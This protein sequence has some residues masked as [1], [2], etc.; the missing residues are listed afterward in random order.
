MNS[1]TFAYVRVSTAEQNTDRQTAEL[2]KYV[3]D[4]K[5][6]IIDKASGKDFNRPNYQALRQLSTAGDTIIVKSLDRLGRNKEAIKE[7]LAYFKNKGVRIRC[8]DLPTTM[9]DTGS[10]LI[11][12]TITNIL[13]EVY[14]MIAEQERRN[15]RQRQAEGIAQAKARGQHLGR[16][17]AEYPS[18]WTEVYNQ[19][20][21]NQITAVKAIELLGM[22]RSTF[23]KLAKQYKQKQQ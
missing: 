2:R 14:G 23:Y 5:N 4:E 17:K 20:Q 19:W 21:D 13:I 11:L 8:L 6:I 10:D 15:I 1:R 16:H 22:K 18:N 7:E 12:D 3:D 9:I